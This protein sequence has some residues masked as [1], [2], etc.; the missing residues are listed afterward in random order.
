MLSEPYWR[1][2]YNNYT[3]NP[4]YCQL[5]N[6]EETIFKRTNLNLIFGRILHFYR[7]YLEQKE[8]IQNPIGI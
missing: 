4:L 5:K 8:L 7:L 3:G 2:L 1:T 6:L